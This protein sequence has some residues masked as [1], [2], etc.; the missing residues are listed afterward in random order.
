M[1]ISLREVLLTTLY[2]RHRQFHVRLTRTQPH[3]TNVYIPQHQLLFP[4]DYHRFIRSASLMSRE[5]NA[6]CAVCIRCRGLAQTIKSDLDNAPH[7]GKTT[8]ADRYITLHYHPI[9]IEWRK[10]KTSI[11]TRQSLINGL[12]DDLCAFSIGVERIGKEVGTTVK[13][14]IE[15]D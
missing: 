5:A 3:L 10:R 1:L 15:V 2:G 4:C 11:I 6:P 13:R 14:R 7:I 12:G 8:E 9:G